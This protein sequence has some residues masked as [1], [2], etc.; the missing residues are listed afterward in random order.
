MEGLEIIGLVV[1]AAHDCYEMYMRPDSLKQEVLGPFLLICDRVAK[2]LQKSEDGKYH[3]IAAQQL[4]PSKKRGHDM[5][6]G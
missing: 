2:S 1:S 4:S 5:S 6:I 3:I